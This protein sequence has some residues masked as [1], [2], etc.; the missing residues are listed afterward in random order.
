MDLMKYKD[1]LVLAKD[2][3][4]ELMAPLR[5]Y[6]MKKK[7]ELEV[8]KLEGVIAEREQAIQQVASEY[9]INF[10]GLIDSLDDLELTK[11]RLTQFN[12]IIK[13]MFEDKE[14]K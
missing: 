7:A 9:P 2:K 8:A 1:V 11:R 12:S 14:V 4:K 6:E 5:A 10:D 3:I 13:D